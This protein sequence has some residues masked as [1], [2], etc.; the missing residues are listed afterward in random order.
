MDPK[1]GKTPET[2][3]PED[4]AGKKNCLGDTNWRRVLIEG[5][6]DG[7][8]VIDREGRVYETSKKFAQTLGYTIDEVFNLCVWDWDSKLSKE[9]ITQM[10]ATVDEKGDQFETQHRRKD[11]SLV[12]VE[13]CTNAAELDGQKL[14]LCVCRD[15]TDRINA[16]K[17][18]RHSEARLTALSDASFESIFLSEQGICLDQNL[19]A[20]R[21]FGYTREEALG[22]PGMEWIA[23]EDRDTVEKNMLSG[24]EKPYEVTALRKDGTRFPAEIQGRMLRYNENRIRVT[25]LRDITDRKRAQKE[26]MEAVTEAA[27][28]RKLAL[29][30]QVAGK[31][32]HDFN[33]ILGIMMGT[34]E[35]ALMSGTAPGA[36]EPLEIILEQAVRGRNLTKNLI[37]FAKDQEPKQ[38]F[39]SVNEKIE[40][41][42]NLMKRDLEGI[43]VVREYGRRGPDLLAD[44]GMIEHAIV[45]IIQNSIHA[46]SLVEQPE[47][48][49]RT[50]HL[51]DKI[52][53]EIR[54]NGC[55]IPEECLDR[56]FEPSFTLKGR[57]DRTRCYK[58][59]IK[60]TG[61]G[62]ANVKK[63]VEK[64]KGRIT[65]SSE[66]GKGTAISIILPLTKK[67]LTRK[68]IETIK[69]DA[70]CCHDKY[71]LLVEDEQALADIQYRIL[72]QSPCRHRVDIASNGR[73]ALDL[74]DRNAY[75]FVSLDYILPG[76]INGMEVYD[77]IRKTDKTV[78]VLFI[79]GN[80]EFLESI[81]DLKEN[82]PYTDHLSKPC[83][84]VDYLNSINRLFEI[85]KR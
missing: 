83:M 37:A 41:V 8:V 34:A 13:I 16:Q 29:V 76:E 28:S 70:V 69:A 21:M 48:V 35:L 65:V 6:R 63:Y 85:A 50:S 27:E 84:N 15:I 46:T 49:I 73:I 33:N 19:T 54:D 4:S 74:F 61:Y 57:R 66:P 44:S 60:G 11:G 64:H 9:Q 62:M 68:E 58:G 67:K 7:I 45:N 77:H 39:F 1:R 18:L 31:M 78:P 10:L 71:I 52:H 24:Y 2:G 82:D 36:A 81:K 56:I 51:D 3:S 22:R 23:P 12:D 59:G 47:I 30:G 17:A 14:I 40:L 55:G 80:I 38:E 53:I 43:T 75:D 72:T 26:K 42:L 5:S 32:A 25:A 79:S 20:H